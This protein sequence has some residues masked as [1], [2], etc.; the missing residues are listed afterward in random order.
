M[1]YLQIKPCVWEIL[2]A[3]INWPFINSI[4]REKPSD[5]KPITVQRQNLFFVSPK[6]PYFF[7][8]TLKSLD[9]MFVRSIHAM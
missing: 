4:M 2:Y 9:F 8:E 7:K 1:S 6:V 5:E 3:L